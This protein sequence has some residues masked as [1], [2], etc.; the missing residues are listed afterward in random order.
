MALVAT[1]QRGNLMPERQRGQMERVQQV[2]PVE[3]RGAAGASD[4][5]DGFGPAT[6]I[7]AQ[8]TVQSV[9]PTTGAELQPYLFVHV[10]DTFDGQHWHSLG[11][12]G[13]VQY[14]GVYAIDITTPF[15]DT[16]RVSWL[17]DRGSFEFSVDWYV[18]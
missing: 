10:Q 5:F 9:A 17:P 8:L 3:A 15:T 6:Q 16:L 13:N 11:S 14:V 1:K 4:A 18:Q 12:F 7:R 2:V